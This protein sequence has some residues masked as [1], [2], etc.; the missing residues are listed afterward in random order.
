MEEMIGLQPSYI[1]VLV[2]YV[3]FLGSARVLRLPIPCFRCQKAGKRKA[4]ALVKVSWTAS[5]MKFVLV[6]SW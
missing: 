3:L 6:Y 4:Y 5:V 1:A 2:G